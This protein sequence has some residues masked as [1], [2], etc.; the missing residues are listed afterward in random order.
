MTEQ[1]TQPTKQKSEGM[2]RD[3][4]GNKSSKRI[5]GFALVLAGALFL[6][7]TGSIALGSQVA[8]AQTALDVGRTLI[9]TGA[10]LLGVG[11]TEK[12]AKARSTR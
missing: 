2:F 8:D 1:G 9:F 11:V 3:G 7:L 5:V 10:G 12:F 4:D 6:V